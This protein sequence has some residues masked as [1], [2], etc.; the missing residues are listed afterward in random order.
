MVIER[1]AHPRLDVGERR[2]DSAQ[3]PHEILGELFAGTFT[4]RRRGDRTQDRGRRLGGDRELGATREQ[5][6]QHRMELLG[7]TNPLRRKVRTAFLE[8]R[9]HRRVILRVLGRGRDRR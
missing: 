6:A 2:V 4:R 5:I 3:V 7:Y 9:E 8:H 1:G